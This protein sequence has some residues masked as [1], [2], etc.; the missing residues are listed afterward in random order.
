[1][2]R[3]STFELSLLH[4]YIHIGA[5]PHTNIYTHTHTYIFFVFKQLLRS[6]IKLSSQI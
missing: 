3:T 2:K 6:L 1:M 5:R 4:F